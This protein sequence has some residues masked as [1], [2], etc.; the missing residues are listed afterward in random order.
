MSTLVIKKALEVMD[1]GRKWT[2]DTRSHPGD[3]FCV[4]TALLEAHRKIHGE[5]MEYD[6]SPE[7]LHLVLMA[8]NMS[9][10]SDL[11]QYNDHP[12]RKWSEIKRLLESA[13]S[14]K[15]TG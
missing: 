15:L 12:G 13:A 14:D 4:Y 6:C 11:I 8:G 2:Q 10:I 3:K 9:R 1:G 5:G 7:G